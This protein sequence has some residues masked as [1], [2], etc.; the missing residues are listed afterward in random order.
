MISGAYSL[1]NVVFQSHAFWN[2]NNF[3]LK[4]LV[5]V[6]R[7]KIGFRVYWVY[8]NDDQITEKLPLQTMENIFRKL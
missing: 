8:L 5:H 2:K 1:S 6:I 4:K 3:G 7:N